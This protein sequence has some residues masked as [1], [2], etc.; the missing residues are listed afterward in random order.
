MLAASASDGIQLLSLLMT[1][2]LLLKANSTD[3][4]VI[5][6]ISKSCALILRIGKVFEFTFH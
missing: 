6:S 5:D 2:P 4:V 3:G 1:R